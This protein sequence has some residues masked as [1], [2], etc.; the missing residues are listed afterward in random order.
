[1]PQ[2][3]VRHGFHQGR[4][5]QPLV[6]FAPSLLGRLPRPLLRRYDGA[7]RDLRGPRRDAPANSPALPA[8]NLLHAALD[9]GQILRWVVHRHILPEQGPCT[10]IHVVTHS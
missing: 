9:L 10:H 2:T 3:A 6:S 4:L 7:D 1:M 5:K 8:L